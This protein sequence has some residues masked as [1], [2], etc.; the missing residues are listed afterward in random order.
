MPQPQLTEGIDEVKM[1][2]RKRIAERGQT[3]LEKQMGI[4]HG[5]LSHVISGRKRVSPRMAAKFGF[6]AV[7]VYRRMQR[8]A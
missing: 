1:V 8:R 6:D 5:S 7:L 3:A 2:L 4:G